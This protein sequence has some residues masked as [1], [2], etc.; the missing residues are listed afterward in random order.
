MSLSRGR[1]SPTL[2]NKDFPSWASC[3]PWGPFYWF[4]LPTSV[5]SP[6]KKRILRPS[7]EGKC[8]PLF[9]A[10]LPAGS[11]HL[12]LSEGLPLDPG[13]KNELPGYLLLLLDEKSEKCQVWVAT[14]YWLRYAKWPASVLFFWSWVSKPA[15]LLFSTL[16]SFPLLISCA[17]SRNYK[18]VLSKEE[19][20]TRSMSSCPDQKSLTY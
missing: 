19:Q 20:G 1:K 6:W 5:I 16:Q 4:L 15:F 2:G 9:L 13:G 10:R 8:I 18:A 11:P 7:R 14:F 3:F 12:R 17:T